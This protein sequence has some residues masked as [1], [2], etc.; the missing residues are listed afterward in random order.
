MVLRG[1]E[2]PFSPTI[3]ILASP[4]A[5]R[6]ALDQDHP[7]AIGAGTS[8]FCR[9]QAVHGHLAQRCQLTTVGS[10]QEAKVASPLLWLYHAMPSVKGLNQ[11]DQFQSR[12]IQVPTPLDCMMKGSALTPTFSIGGDSNASFRVFCFQLCTPLL[13]F[14]IEAY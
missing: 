1:T 8:E 11:K 7:T 3:L 9:D 12:T 13:V 14:S 5:V 2:S 10:S 6:F 4:A